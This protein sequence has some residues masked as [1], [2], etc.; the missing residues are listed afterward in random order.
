MTWFGLML[1]VCKGAAFREAK[2]PELARWLGGSPR[3][4]IMRDESYGNPFGGREEGSSGRLPII[5]K[6]NKE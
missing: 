1:S 5:P 2:P 4:P 6:T 3:P